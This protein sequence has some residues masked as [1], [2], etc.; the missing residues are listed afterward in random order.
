MPNLKGKNQFLMMINGEDCIKDPVSGRFNRPDHQGKTE[1][2]KKVKTN[3]Q[4]LG[5]ESERKW[6]KVD[7]PRSNE[8]ND[9]G[10]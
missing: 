5:D 9:T 7:R 2:D 1:I 10:K 3:K 6:T 4:E 8:T